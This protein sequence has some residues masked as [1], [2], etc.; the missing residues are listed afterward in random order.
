MASQLFVHFKQRINEFV[1]NRTTRSGLFS[2]VRWD[3]IVLFQV[4]FESRSSG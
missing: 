3:F 4:Y 2:E 1:N